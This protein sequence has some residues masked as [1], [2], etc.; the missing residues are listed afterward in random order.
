MKKPE[1]GE[2]TFEKPSDGPEKVYEVLPGVV[3]FIVSHEPDF[4]EWNV[5]I[6]RVE[7]CFQHVERFLIYRGFRIQEKAY[8]M[9]RGAE[10]E[11]EA[12]WNLPRLLYNRRWFGKLSF[13]VS[14]RS[15]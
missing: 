13:T 14:V 7:H 6:P 11:V 1:T 3:I 9:Q 4:L 15:K 10:A 2:P 12:G 5:G 8:L